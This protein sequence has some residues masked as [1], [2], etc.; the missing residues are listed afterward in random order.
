[1]E[2]PVE[3]RAYRRHYH[4]TEVKYSDYASNSYHSAKMHN[5][6]LD[7]LCFTSE[8]PI[9]TGSDICVKIEDES[10]EHF[11]IVDKDGYRAEVIWCNQVGDPEVRFYEIGAQYY[12]TLKK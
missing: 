10:I 6:S 12:E 8:Y 11:G 1:M 9:Q 5:H 7:G 2:T 3:K 4:F